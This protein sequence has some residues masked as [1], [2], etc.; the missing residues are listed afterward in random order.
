MAR[1]GRPKLGCGVTYGIH[2]RVSEEEY[3]NIQNATIRSGMSISELVR[4]ATKEYVD[5]VLG[6]TNRMSRDWSEYE[7]DDYY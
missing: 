2:A 6:N 3:E 7:D 1:R 4:I 5:K